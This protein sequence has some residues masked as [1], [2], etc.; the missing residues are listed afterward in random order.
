MQTEN[1]PPVV[2]NTF[3]ALA[4]PVGVA[5]CISSKKR[6]E[7]SIPFFLYLRPSLRRKVSYCPFG[8]LLC[9]PCSFSLCCMCHRVLSSV[10]SHVLS[11]KPPFMNRTWLTSFVDVRHSLK[12]SSLKWSYKHY[13]TRPF[14][15]LALKASKQGDP[16]YQPPKLLSLS[17][18][19]RWG[20][21]SFYNYSSSYSHTLSH[22]QRSFV[23]RTG[24]SFASPCVQQI[25][26]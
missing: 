26:R 2:V 18:N 14:L 3:Q 15:S 22:T 10:L 17:G 1:H 12:N 8:C 7:T 16:S 23:T 20:S 4:D 19:S 11:L 21:V 5:F 24:L 9:F 13:H 6:D 25:I